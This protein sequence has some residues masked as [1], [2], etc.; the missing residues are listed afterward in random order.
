MWILFLKGARIITPYHFLRSSLIHASGIVILV[1]YQTI[2]FE[3]L[4]LSVCVCKLNEFEKPPV[5]LFSF[6]LFPQCYFLSVLFGVD[7]SLL[8]A[9]IIS[10]NNFNLPGCLL[11]WSIIKIK[12]WSFWQNRIL[13]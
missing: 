9:S 3:C 5:T 12:V 13:S 10:Y 2:I 6:L 8:V 1:L 4:Y 7:S 11:D